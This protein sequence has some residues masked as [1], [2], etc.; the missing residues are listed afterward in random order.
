MKRRGM[1]LLTVLTLVCALC[2]TGAAG[3]E[4]LAELR[5]E[6]ANGWQETLTDK[7]GTSVTVNAA[8][9]IRDG[10]EEV[11]ALRVSA[12]ASI[13]EDRLDIFDRSWNG[14]GNENGTLSQLSPAMLTGVDALG[15][16]LGV[17]PQGRKV[18]DVTGKGGLSYEA[19]LK[20]A[21]EIVNHLF[22][23]GMEDYELE[24]AEIVHWENRDTCR[25]VF[26]PVVSGRLLAARPLRWTFALRRNGA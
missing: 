2:A 11:S 5:T 24:F 23:T 19:A 15:A 8:I 25:Y 3:A 14:Q 7:N 26:A 16:F 21:D 17:E 1:T 6:T 9:E 13:P 20:T 10:A 4:T 18:P 12:G 22:G